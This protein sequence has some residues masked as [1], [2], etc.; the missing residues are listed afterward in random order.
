[1]AT[2]T[3]EIEGTVEALR[4]DLEDILK[5]YPISMEERSFVIERV[6]EAINGILKIQH[7]VFS[8]KLAEIRDQISNEREKVNT[9][10]ENLKQAATAKIAEANDKIGQAYEK[11]ASDASREVEENH[12]P[13]T[14]NIVLA[15]FFAALAFVFVASTIFGKSDSGKGR[16]KKG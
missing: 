13:S 15:V 5:K 10:V 16:D 3:S 4:K 14:L 1:M 6:D 9:Q 7:G 12:G 2:A 11:G 8:E